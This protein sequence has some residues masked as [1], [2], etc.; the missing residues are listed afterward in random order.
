[1][2]DWW[3]RAEEKAGLAPK[4]GRGWHSLRRKFAS[5]LM[6]APPKELCELGGWKDYNTILKCYQFPDQ[7]RLA[8]TLATRSGPS[9]S[10]ERAQSGPV[11]EDPPETPKLRLIK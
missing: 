10:S 1:M 11:E 4:R 7:D 3:K 9:G 2:R 5:D 8:S 6:H